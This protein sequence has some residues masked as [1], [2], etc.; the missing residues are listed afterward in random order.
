M[1]VDMKSFM[2]ALHESMVVSSED[3]S[4][5]FPEGDPLASSTEPT[6]M[7][8]GS[9]QQVEDHDQFETGQQVQLDVNVPKGPLETRKAED[10]Q[11]DLD[12]S[13]D[14]ELEPPQDFDDLKSGEAE[15]NIGQS[16][17]SSDRIPEGPDVLGLDEPK[18]DLAES[19]G[20]EEYD[21]ELYQQNLFEQ[22]QKGEKLNDD[23][24]FKI[25]VLPR[26]QQGKDIDQEDLDDLELLHEKL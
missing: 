21:E 4:S 2:K 19:P 13:K 6:K 14:V 5:T 17:A 25:K 10:S 9:G 12:P 20:D 15:Y 11:E 18:S 22:Q 8:D 26:Q 24:L 16:G 3:E 7:I 23:K 1:G